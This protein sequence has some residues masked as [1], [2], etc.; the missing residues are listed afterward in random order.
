MVRGVGSVRGGGVKRSS[1]AHVGMLRPGRMPTT[2]MTVELWVRVAM[3]GF[4]QP[5][6]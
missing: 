3:K 5:L 6:T 1:C 2:I 4:Y